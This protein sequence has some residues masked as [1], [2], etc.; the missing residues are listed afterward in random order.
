MRAQQS[1]RSKKDPLR[2]ILGAGLSVVGF[3]GLTLAFSVLAGS[4]ANSNLQAIGKGLRLPV[5]YLF[6]LGFALLVIYAVLRFKASAPSRERNEPA[7]SGSYMTDFVS[8]LHRT[9]PELD[10]LHGMSRTGLAPVTAWS[11]QVFEG[12]GWQRFEALCARLF[13]QAGCEV[14]TKSHGADGGL[15]IWLHSQQMEEPAAVVHC[16]HG[17][18]TPVGVVEIRDFQGVMASRKLL[19]GTFATS[20]TFTAD[21][22][23]FAKGNGISTFDGQGLLA[24]ISSR[25][26]AEQEALLAIA[27]S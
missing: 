11:A 18:G 5:P 27:H 15:D 7:F 13:A 6:L 20:S 8:H 2:P 3:G 17:P 4:S 12:I 23:Q 16:R 14:R 25:T 24:L 22:L 21:A 9:P 26:P 1:R 10:S 19:R